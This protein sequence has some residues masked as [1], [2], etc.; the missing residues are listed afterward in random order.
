MRHWSNKRDSSGL[1]F[2]LVRLSGKNVSSALFS[3]VKYVK[4][5]MEWTLPPLKSDS[6]GELING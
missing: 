1:W 3:D 5:L 4:G 2:A 6:V